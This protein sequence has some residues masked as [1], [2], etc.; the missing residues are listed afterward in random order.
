LLCALKAQKTYQLQEDTYKQFKKLAQSNSL[1]L[2]VGEVNEIDTVQ[3][4]LEAKAQLNE[5]YQSKAEMQ[6]ALADLVRL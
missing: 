5:V 1:R 3:S 4:A 6:N 2:S